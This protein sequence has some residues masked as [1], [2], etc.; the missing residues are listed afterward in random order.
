MKKGLFTFLF[1]VLFSVLFA[2]SAWAAPF[3]TSN[4]QTNV[5]SYLVT[6]DGVEQEVIAQDMG[7][8]TTILHFDLTGLADGDHTGEVKAKNIWGESDPFPFSFNKAIPDSLSVLELT[9]Q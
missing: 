3:L 5:T 9:A 8:D 4:P 7:D 1:S 2:L 6:L